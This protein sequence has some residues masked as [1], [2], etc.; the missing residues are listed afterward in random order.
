[1]DELGKKLRDRRKAMGISLKQLG[2]LIGSAPSYLSMVE[3]GKIDPSLSRLKKIANGLNITVIELFQEQNNDDFVV[4]KN[5]RKSLDFKDFR[6]EILVPQKRTREIDAR[7]AIINPK[8]STGGF[9]S[10]PG[11]EFGFV[12]K[13]TLKLT[14]KDLTRQLYEGD[15]FY[16]S[17][18]DRHSVQNIGEENAIVLWVNHPPTW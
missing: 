11:E 16:F 4:R 7:L 6:V 18:K 2:K 3:N 9:Y 1:M 12:L 13:G 10:H 8:G 14:V 17:S 15:S 5:A